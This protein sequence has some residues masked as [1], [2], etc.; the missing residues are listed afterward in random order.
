MTRAA[1]R[2]ISALG[3][4][5][6]VSPLIA[7]RADAQQ[8][9][10]IAETV[11]FTS[12]GVDA[13]WSLDLETLPARPELVVE[14]FPPSTHPNMQLEIRIQDFS[15]DG[16]PNACPD[17]TTVI[18]SAAG[19]GP[20]NVRWASWNCDPRT[21]ALV[22]E[23]ANVFV[24][25]VSFG[26]SVLNAKVSVQIY[27]ETIVP[28]GTETTA[29]EPTF[30]P[31]TVFLDAAKDSTIYEADPSGSNGLGEFL[32]AGTDASFPSGGGVVMDEL[33]SL[34]A[35][36]IHGPVPESA[37]VNSAELTIDVIDAFAGDEVGLYRVGSDLLG[38]P[39]QTWSEGD[40]AA[41]GNEFFAGVS[42]SPA[43]TWSDRISSGPTGS[44]PWSL[45][46]GEPLGSLSSPLAS[47]AMAVGPQT[48]SSPALTA[49]VGDMVANDDD[50][51]G[52]VIANLETWYFDAGIQ[53]KSRQN[54]SGGGPRMVV[55]YTPTVPLVV[56]EA[57][58]GVV[59]F[60]NEGEN[61]R[62][63]YDL[64]D[65]DI[66]ETDIGGV[67]TAVD[68][69]APGY[70]TPYTYQYTGT[71][72]FTGYDCC[73]W[74]IDSPE[75]GTVGAGQAIFFHNL[76]PA[77]L[78]PD[79][80][81]DGIRDLCDNC[82]AIPNG[83]LLG[84]CAAGPQLGSVCR[85][86]VECSGSLCSLSQEDADRNFEGDVCVPEP[87]FVWMLGMGG[88]MLAFRPRAL[89]STRGASVDSAASPMPA[90]RRLFS[91]CAKFLSITG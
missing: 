88:M 75:T 22:G 47:R 8:A 17:E 5:C 80:D 7:W 68:P 13:S 41:A 35:F 64:D 90:R 83:P 54:L 84:T 52:F 34:V 21:S 59:N 56:G 16:G 14:A 77:N 31:Q 57:D 25:V 12:T 37:I 20:K 19:P 24:R 28:T 44:V 79:S 15:I 73:L 62:W 49:A 63:I 18:T 70:I 85:S 6:F 10:P 36:D 45:P 66:L 3:L 60:I 55:T 32:W 27:G 9:I 42:S 30:A 1:L 76:D 81:G 33:R 40:A 69:A 78:P 86:N 91:S 53:M 39:P 58:A 71:P 38:V 26:S 46:G 11:T 89:Q 65:D 4:L 51:D 29:F 48:F 61:F 72:G 50:Q 43:A 87:G 82:V 67:C 2:F 74:A 23:T